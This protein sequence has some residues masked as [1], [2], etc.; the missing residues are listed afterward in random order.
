MTLCEATFMSPVRRSRP[1]VVAHRGASK[2]A[3]ENTLE[4]FALAGA[5]GAAM[6]E[7][8][9][10]RATDG[11][12][13]VHHDPFVVRPSYAPTLVDALDVCVAHGMEVNIEIK[14]SQ[15]DPDFDPDDSIAAEVVALLRAR[16][17]GARMLIS[18]FNPAT[19]AAA[20][21]LDPKL[22]TGY[23]FMKRPLLDTAEV[24]EAG[25]VAIHPFDGDVTPALVAQAHARRLDVNV[26]TVDDPSRMRELA[27]W[28][29]DAIITNVPDVA[30]K[31]L[32]D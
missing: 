18:S 23:L 19:I 24:A 9:V 14:N 8:D 15:R 10:R 3:Q 32:A 29:V 12:L 16:G 13:V 7:L 27:A 25:H 4:A 21:R 26:W 17:D 20:H 5:M 11:E 6:V 2:A 31:A 22:R 28:H 1:I 30:L